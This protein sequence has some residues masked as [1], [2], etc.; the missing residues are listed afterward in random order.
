MNRYGRKSVFRWRTVRFTFTKRWSSSILDVAFNLA[1]LNERMDGRQSDCDFEEKSKTVIVS[2]PI[3]Y[4]LFTF[5]KSPG[6]RSSWP[7]M[8]QCRR[9]FHSSQ[10]TR[11][12]DRE[13]KSRLM[14]MRGLPQ[15][16]LLYIYWQPKGNRSAFHPNFLLFPS[17]LSFLWRQVVLL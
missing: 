12:V 8:S 1:K 9:C 6:S 10:P 5:A 11:A 17:K 16:R 4:R 14:Y 2:F 15:Y 7:D 13:E 3:P